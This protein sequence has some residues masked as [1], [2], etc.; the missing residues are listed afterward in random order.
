MSRNAPD[1]GDFF[2]SGY[3]T[4]VSGVP[5]TARTGGP[6]GEPG[7]RGTVEPVP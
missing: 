4:G 7:D 6:V 3:G 1:A 5:R 2:V